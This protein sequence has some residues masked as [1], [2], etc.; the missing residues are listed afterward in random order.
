MT[1]Q[2][3]TQPSYDWKECRLYIGRSFT[4]VPRCPRKADGQSALDP[5]GLSAW[6][7]LSGRSFSSANSVSSLFFSSHN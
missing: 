6:S 7:V 5:F 4:A 2:K 1:G 3:S